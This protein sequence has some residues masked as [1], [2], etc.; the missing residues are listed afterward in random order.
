IASEACKQC[1]RARVPEVHAPESLDAVLARAGSREIK[2]VPWEAGGTAMKSI[3]AASSVALLV[4]PDGGL[5]DAEGDR[6]KSRG[7]VPVSLGPRILR[8]ET[9]GIAAVAAAQLLWGDLS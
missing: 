6:A 1:G 2:V 5:A 3:R 8:T 7:F 9:A 4:G